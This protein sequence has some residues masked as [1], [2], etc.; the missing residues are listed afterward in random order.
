MNSLIKFFIIFLNIIVLVIGFLWYNNP[1]GNY[2]P[3]AVI[4]V[5]IITLLTLLFE[6]KI[7]KIVTKKVNNS[8]IN[9]DS[10]NGQDIVTKK[11]N[12]SKIRINTK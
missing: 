5:Q 10:N 11:I 7:S 3:M 1:N 2:E 9:I 6:N 4:I 8:E 12:D